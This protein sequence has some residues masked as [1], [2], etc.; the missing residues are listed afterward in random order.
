VD[1]NEARTW[2][3]GYLDGEIDLVRAVEIEQHLKDCGDCSRARDNHSLLHESM[4]ATGLKYACPPRLRAGIED[5]LRRE[6]SQLPDRSRTQHWWLAIAASMVLVAGFSWLALRAGSADNRIAQDVI[7]SHVRSLLVDHLTDVAS[8]DRHTVKPWFAG[9]LDF[10]PA[11]V[12]YASDGFPLS[13]GR[14]DYLDNQ[15][16]AAVVYHR[17]KHAINLFT[18]PATADDTLQPKFMTSH[19]YQLFHWAKAGGEY[20]AISDLNRNELEH[21]V[22]LILK[23]GSSNDDKLLP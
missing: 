23:N 1:C 7:A 21:F 18:W 9:K 8:S 14:V 12:D 15:P 4:Q 17:R 2:L 16:V 13:G 10:S 22:Q 5:A 3:P 19:G 6:V 11:V 20:W